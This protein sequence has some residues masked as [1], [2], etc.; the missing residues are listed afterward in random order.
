MC[1]IFHIDPICWPR[2]KRINDVSTRI[3]YIQLAKANEEEEQEEE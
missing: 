3:L 1:L 2:I